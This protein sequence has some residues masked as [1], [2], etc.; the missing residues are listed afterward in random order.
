[1]YLP[2]LL[3]HLFAGATDP[4]A[5]DTNYLHAAFQAYGPHSFHAKDINPIM[6]GDWQSLIYQILNLHWNKSH[7][8]AVKSMFEDEYSATVESFIEG[9]Y[10]PTAG[11]D[12]MFIPL[13]MALVNIE[14][15]QDMINFSNDAESQVRSM[16]DI[17]K[18]RLPTGETSLQLGGELDE[19]TA[20]PELPHEPL[21]RYNKLS[22]YQIALLKVI[23]LRKRSAHQKESTLQ[24]LLRSLEDSEI[25]AGSDAWLGR[26]S[27]YP[28]FQECPTFLGSV[29]P[30]LTLQVYKAGDIILAKSEDATWAGWLIVGRT[31]YIANYNPNEPIR[32]GRRQ[33]TTSENALTFGLVGTLL[34]LPSLSHNVAE[35]PCVVAQIPKADFKR[36][37]REHEQVEQHLTTEEFGTSFAVA[38]ECLRIEIT[39]GKPWW[40]VFDPEG[41]STFDLTT[42]TSKVLEAADDPKIITSLARSIG[43]VLYKPLDLVLRNR[44]IEAAKLLLESG[45]EVHSTT[46]REALDNDDADFIELLLTRPGGAEA[47]NELLRSGYTTYVPKLQTMLKEMQ[48][49]VFLVTASSLQAVAELNKQTNAPKPM[50]EEQ[51]LTESS[52]TKETDETYEPETLEEE[53]DQDSAAAGSKNSFHDETGDIDT[54]SEEEES[55]QTS[56]HPALAKKTMWASPLASIRQRWGAGVSSTSVEGTEP[57][58]PN[59]QPEADEVDEGVDTQS[60]VGGIAHAALSVDGA[61]DLSQPSPNL[62]PVVEDISATSPERIPSEV[63]Q[64]SGDAAAQLAPAQSFVPENK[65]PFSREEFWSAMNAYGQSES[66][67]EGGSDPVTPLLLHFTDRSLA[68]SFLNSDRSRNDDSEFPLV[69]AISNETLDLVELLLEYGADPNITT[70]K[71]DHPVDYTHGSDDEGSAITRDFIRHTLLEHGADKVYP[72]KD[73]FDLVHQ[74]RAS[75]E[76][77][78]QVRQVLEASQDPRRT[79]NI[80]SSNGH[81]ALDIAVAVNDVD[82]VL[83]LLESGATSGDPDGLADVLTRSS[84]DDAIVQA[85]QLHHVIRGRNQRLGKYR[86]L[87]SSEGSVHDIFEEVEESVDSE[88]Q[89]AEHVEEEQVI[90]DTDLIGRRDGGEPASSALKEGFELS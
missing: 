48:G 41:L 77:R 25:S 38:R 45:A 28:V 36:L 29:K 76:G 86:K 72:S 34:D 8:R 61:H 51:P 79:V 20:T 49:R 65:T 27:R 17:S 56:G 75:E 5:R 35:T 44:N 71:G 15:G 59:T 43:N 80:P 67:M 13:L 18:R 11:R 24:N 78:S 31:T 68:A 37:V 89:T 90:I 42:A 14:T 66:N 54:I 73:W 10:D 64:E 16:D 55:S 74:A 60:Q 22:I 85:L 81:R 2:Y 33:W 1:M 84:T 69:F 26:L 6:S 63:E 23:V 50:E 32:Q 12:N 58:S 4:V 3:G 46:I 57:E 83:F 30:Y 62:A 88:V 21:L 39:F 53:E 47:A 40:Y 87:E 19:L 7:L 9:L 82:T 52:A 70:S